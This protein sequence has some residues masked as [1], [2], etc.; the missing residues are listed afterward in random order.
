[1]CQFEKCIYQRNIRLVLVFVLNLFNAKLFVPDSLGSWSQA[2]IRNLNLTK[3]SFIDTSRYS[4][5]VNL[6]YLTNLRSLNVSYT[7]LNQQSLQMICEDLK[8]LERLDL[9]G[10][11]VHDLNPLLLLADQLI[12]VTISVREYPNCFYFILIVAVSGFKTGSNLPKRN[13]KTLQS[14]PLGH[15]FSKRKT[16]YL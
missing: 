4:F 5:M 9:S 14:T 12:S 1:M 2:H 6:T 16:G 8:H 15:K 7:E 10:T 11:F 13:N 3:C